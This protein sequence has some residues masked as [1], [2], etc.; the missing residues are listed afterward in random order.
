[1]AESEHCGCGWWWVLPAE[2]LLMRLPVRSK[3]LMLLLAL[4]TQP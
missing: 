1:M 3:P 2:Q 4:T